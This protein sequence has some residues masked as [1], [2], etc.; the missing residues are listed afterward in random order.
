MSE[1]KL[2]V[3]WICHFSDERTRQNL[4]FNKYYFHKVI[5]WALRKNSNVY[6]DFAQWISNSI[7]Y[8]ENSKD[9]DLTIIFPHGGI[10]GN[11]QRFDL[12]GIHYVAFRSQT[13]H[14]FS[15]VKER[16]LRLPEEVFLKNR[17]VIS[18]MIKTIKPDIVH[19]IGAENPYYSIAALDIPNSI[20][21]IISL[22]TLLSDSGFYENYP[23][24]KKWYNYHSKL[25][26][27]II[28]K[29]TYIGSGSI[30]FK[31]V[32]KKNIFQN[33]IVLK[34]KLAVGVEINT[35]CNSKEY[36]FV[37]FAKNISKAADFAIEAFA[38]AHKE[39]PMLTLNISGAYT[40]NYK[41]KIDKRVNELGIK[42]FVFFSGEQAT[43]E[44]VLEQIKK[45]KYALLP[46]KVDLISGTIREAMAC[47]LPVISTITPATPK[48]NKDRES[49]LLSERGDFQAMANNMIKLVSD[50]KYALRI[51][52]N[53]IITVS[54]LYSNEQFMKMWRK[55]YFEIIDN[56]QKGTPFS[57]DII[58]N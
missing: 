51:K 6:N 53:A 21:S 16:L 2:K 9:I 42:D 47:G 45:S 11:L 40:D 34:M 15:Y 3:V 29:C 33:A 41:Y 12:N 52:D 49:I 18:S 57:D 1:R 48:L 10:E 5:R 17:S 7:K 56:F 28:R 30:Y 38:I 26:K 36:D 27:A 24:S 55:A 20:P 50:E 46:L 4:K 44:K 35:V 58:F 39:S 19:V 54:E 43:H 8:F 32:I 13:D 37:Y 25:E 31:E 23:V 22:Q 14:F